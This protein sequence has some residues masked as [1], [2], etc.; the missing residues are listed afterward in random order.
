[1]VQGQKYIF[2]ENTEN[3]KE[4]V[5]IYSGFQLEGL[6][7]FYFQDYDG[8]TVISLYTLKKLK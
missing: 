3:T 7:Y 8:G 6:P 4:V 5:L 1:M 2:G